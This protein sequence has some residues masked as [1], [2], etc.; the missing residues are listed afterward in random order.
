MSTGAANN[1]SVGVPRS[2]LHSKCEIKDYA[3]VLQPIIAKIGLHS[4]SYAAAIYYPL[5][6]FKTFTVRLGNMCRCGNIIPIIFSLIIIFVF[7]DYT[8]TV[9]LKMSHFPFR[10][11]APNFNSDGVV[12]VRPGLG[13]AQKRSVAFRYMWLDGAPRTRCTNKTAYAFQLSTANTLVIIFYW[14]WQTS[15]QGD[16][17]VFVP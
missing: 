13:I 14:V 12:F 2:E 1:L 17:F 5:I 6:R 11:F 3:H 8:H 4:L 10:T 9:F 16:N 15:M 7:S